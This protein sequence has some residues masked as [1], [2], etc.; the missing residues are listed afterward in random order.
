LELKKYL[1]KPKDKKIL[2][3]ISIVCFF[4]AVLCVIGNDNREGY[5]YL[6][7]F[8]SFSVAVMSPIIYVKNLNRV[9][10]INMDRF[11]ELGLKEIEVVTSFTEDKI[12]LHNKTTGAASELSYGVIERFVKT[13]NMYVLFTKAEQ[14]IVVNR[15]I[16]IEKEKHKD[17]VRFIKEKISV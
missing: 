2:M 10:K 16:L 6:L 5:I 14:F 11:Y 9:I 3:I 4:V 8:F 1:V 15:K 12:K 13:E 7:A 17:F